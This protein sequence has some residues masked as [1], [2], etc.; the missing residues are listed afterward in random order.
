M[1]Q[2]G[3]LKG[4]TSHRHRSHMELINVRSKKVHYLTRYVIRLYQSVYSL[5]LFWNDPKYYHIF[6]IKSY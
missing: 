5:F 4:D 1:C 2:L 3:Q 6:K